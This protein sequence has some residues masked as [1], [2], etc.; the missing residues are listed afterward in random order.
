MAQAE[1]FPTGLKS[2]R[3]Q[4][5]EPGVCFVVGSLL[6]AVLLGQ[7]VRLALLCLEQLYSNLDALLVKLKWAL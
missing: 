2:G 3:R 5:L 4:L 1:A 7:F 6:R